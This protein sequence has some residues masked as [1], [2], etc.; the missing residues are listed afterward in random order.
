MHFACGVEGG[1]ISP[2][3]ARPRTR[4]APSVR[5]GML[6]RTTGAR[7][8]AVEWEEAV[9]VHTLRQNVQTVEVLMAQ[10]LMPAWPRR[11]PN[12]HPGG[13]GHRPHHEGKRGGRFLVLRPRASRWRTYRRSRWRRQKAGSTGLWRSSRQTCSFFSFFLL[14]FFYGD[15][16]VVLLFS[17]VYGSVFWRIWGEGDVVR[18]QHNC[19]SWFGV[20]K[21]YTC[22][23]KRLLLLACEGQRHAAAAIALRA[24]C[25]GI[26]IQDSKQKKQNHP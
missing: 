14:L 24:A 6:Q 5:R 3:T 15:D 7:L 12:M 20:G 19:A 8:R 13:G 23:G 11:L 10:G 18:P 4:D 26:E 21:G 2:P 17:F 9:C 1:A 16:E 25:S 22:G